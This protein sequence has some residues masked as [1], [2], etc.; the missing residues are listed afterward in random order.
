ME[1]LCNSQARGITATTVALDPKRYDKIRNKIA[2][3]VN[4]R[5]NP[6]TPKNC[7]K[8]ARMF[9]KSAL[10]LDLMDVADQMEN[11]FLSYMRL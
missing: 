11:E 8:W 6:Y 1:R 3:R 9:I 5:T 4:E 10:L 2:H 7:A